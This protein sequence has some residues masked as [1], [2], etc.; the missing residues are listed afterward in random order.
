[1]TFWGGS[2]SG[3]GSAD[4]CLVLIDPDPAIFV[5]DLPK[6]PTKNKF[7]KVFLLITFWRYMYIIFKDKKSKRIHKAV[8]MKVFLTFIAW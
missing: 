3:S 7:F 2:G 1:M 8:G 6:M 4:P 5:I